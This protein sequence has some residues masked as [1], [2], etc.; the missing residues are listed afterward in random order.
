[1]FD[2]LF[3]FQNLHSFLCWKAYTVFFVTHFCVENAI[4]L[5]LLIY[6]FFLSVTHF[7][8]ENPVFFISS[9][10]VFFL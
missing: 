4:F 6:F 5:Y 10:I 3:F 7:Y 9:N 1:M 8:V 2:L